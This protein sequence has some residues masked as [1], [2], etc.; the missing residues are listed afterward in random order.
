MS[1]SPVVRVQGG[2]GSPCFCVQSDT[3]IR[4]SPLVPSPLPFPQKR[5]KLMS[6]KRLT[7]VMLLLGSSGTTSACVVRPYRPQWM[8]LMAR[9]R[10]FY[11]GITLVLPMLKG[12]ELSPQP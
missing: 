6:S 10:H 3:R 12:S 4:R 8:C 2:D 9:L 1:S 11:V 5:A 7:S